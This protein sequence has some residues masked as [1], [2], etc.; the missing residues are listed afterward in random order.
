MFSRCH[1]TFDGIGLSDVHNIIE[2]VGFAMLAAE[3]LEV[4]G[5]RVLVRQGDRITLKGEEGNTPDL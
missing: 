1:V 5:Q 2:E 3:I 4:W